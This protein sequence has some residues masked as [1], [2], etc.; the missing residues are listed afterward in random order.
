MRNKAAREQL[1][2]VFARQ[3]KRALS[4]RVEPLQRRVVRLRLL[5]KWIENNEKWIQQAIYADF[6]KPADSVSLSEV[7]PLLTEI[8]DA[9]NNIKSW[10]K[11]VKV[12]S[13]MAYLSTI[14]H[15]AYEPKGVCLIIAPWN[16]PFLLTLGPLVSALAAGNTVML[17][18]SE[19]TPNTSNL[20]D[21]LINEL[22]HEDEVAVFQGDAN[23]SKKLL[24]LPFDH[25][26]FTGSTQ[27]GKIIMSAAA[28][29]LASVT[30]ELGGKSPT[31][32]DE[33]VSINDAAKK[34]AWGKFMN[35]GQTCVAP[36]HLIVHESIFEEFI[37]ALK[38]QITKLFDSENLGFSKSPDYARVINKQHFERLRELYN[39]AVSGGG[40]LIMGGEMI[41]SECFI[42]PTL[43]TDISP[44]SKITSEEVF[45]P[46]LP[47]IKYSS[48]D[49]VIMQVNSQPKP[50]AFYYFGNS[51][52]NRKRLMRETSSGTFCV[53]DCVIQFSHP[54]L[55]FG[56]VN[57]SGMGK[58]H[59]E[60]GFL[61]FSNEKAVLRQ[62]VGLTTTKLVY[63]PYGKRTHIILKLLKKYF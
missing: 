56:G 9:I 25:I 48:L 18:P 24:T 19:M 2:Q 59:G 11:G 58:S 31:V 30:L 22:F 63:P 12:D 50:L 1:D 46:L 62:R 34:I 26:F 4:L 20:I 6:G 51:R 42:S 5:K 52:K 37:T 45:G 49:E 35:N 43:L 28:D 47:I 8:K 27:V 54:N 3:R 14:S 60:Y 21:K 57:H 39:D 32:I 13:S 41:A 33:T 53:N 15:I 7:Y 23:V 10:S 44:V 17:K 55:P 36:D 61:A 40:K 29:H 16:F 38:I